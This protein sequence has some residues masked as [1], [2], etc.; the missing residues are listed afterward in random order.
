MHLYKNIFSARTHFKERLARE[1]PATKPFKCP[2]DGCQVS[3]VILV[4]R[5]EIWISCKTVC[6]SGEAVPGLA[7]GDAAL[8][9]QQARAARALRDGAPQVKPSNLQS[10]S[11]GSGGG[12]AG[13]ASAHHLVIIIIVLYH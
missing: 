13:V 2:V 3:N 5:K 4:R 6:W 10:S 1:L 9:R 12:G 11:L 7:G 8:H